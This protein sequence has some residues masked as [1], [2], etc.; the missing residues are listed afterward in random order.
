M[1][2]IRRA[3]H[4]LSARQDG[5]PAKFSKSRKSLNRLEESMEE[6]PT[7][8]DRLSAMSIYRSRLARTLSLSTTRLRVAPGTNDLYDRYEYDI[9]NAK[10]MYEEGR[11]KEAKR[12]TSRM[13]KDDTV[14]IRAEVRREQN[15]AKRFARDV[16]HYRNVRMIEERINGSELGRSELDEIRAGIRKEA[17][18]MIRERRF[19]NDTDTLLAKAEAFV[20]ELDDAHPPMPPIAESEIVEHTW[21]RPMNLPAE[22]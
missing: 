19:K 22:Y 5:N 7:K 14:D 10:G 20:G 9:W 4:G 17:V 21:S 3:T 6:A 2:P 12:E 18:D 11:M 1:E 13:T 15:A 8:Q 16:G